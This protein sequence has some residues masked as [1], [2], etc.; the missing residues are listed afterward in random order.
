MFNEGGDET[1]AAFAAEEPVVVGD[2]LGEN[3]REIRFDWRAGLGWL[4]PSARPS[5]ILYG[6]RMQM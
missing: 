6:R 5:Q 4:M 1:E 3:W 2:S